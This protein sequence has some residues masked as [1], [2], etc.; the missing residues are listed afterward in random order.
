MSARD[1]SRLACGLHDDGTARRRDVLRVFINGGRGVVVKSPKATR[2]TRA[3]HRRFRAAARVFVLRVVVV[4]FVARFLAVAFL[5]DLFFADLLRAT[6]MLSTRL[7]Y[8]RPAFR[9]RP[10][11]SAFCAA[12]SL[13]GPLL[14][15]LFFLGFDR[16]HGS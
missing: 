7:G 4:R 13:R 6:A 16:S 1:L 5:D 14:F 11:A 9:A 15:A 2:F 10:R 3:A 8:L 12:V